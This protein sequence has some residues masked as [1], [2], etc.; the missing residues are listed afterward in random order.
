MVNDQAVLDSLQQMINWGILTTDADLRVTGLNAWFETNCGRA[1][2]EI[3]GRSLLDAFPEVTARNLDHRYRQV[4]AGSAA[5]LSQRLHGYVFAM[6]S[7]VEGSQFQLMQ[8]SV[9][10]SPLVNDGQVVGTLTLVEDVTERVAFETGLRDA[11]RRKNEF[12]AM[13]AHELRN[14]LAPIQNAIQFLRMKGPSDQDLEWARDVIERQVQQMTRLV[15]DLLDASRITTGKI[16][17]TMEPVV[18]TRIIDGALEVSRP[19]IDSHRHALS[20]SLPPK[21]V[22]LKGDS[23]RL[24][25]VLSNLLNNAAKYTPP[26]GSVALTAVH[27]GAEVVIGVRD[28]GMGIPGEMLPHIFDLFTQVNRSLDRSEGGLGI[29]LTL[30]RSLVDMHGGSVHA[31]SEGSGRGSVFL[32]RLPV[33]A[34]PEAKSA[35]AE[36]RPGS[37]ASAVSRRILVV[38]DNADSARTLALLLKKAGNTVA[39]AFTGTEAIER[40]AADRP[41]IVFLDIGLPG[42]SGL[43]VAQRVRGDEKLNSCFLVALS[44]YGQDEDREKSTAAGFDCHLVKPVNLQELTAVLCRLPVRREPTID[45]VGVGGAN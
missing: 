45:Q 41:E 6:P 30:V 32:V 20:V 42:M 11:D 15:N 18:L 13:L 36:P 39:V 27:E 16:S 23:T 40:I 9:R 19:V 35:Q 1:K 26:G 21:A 12:L 25:Q 22:W 14:P 24:V 28:S 33:L 10:I 44:G 31:S 34:P 7:S 29:G 8:Q 5:V 38:D 43:E 4:L 17:L 3:V 37:D 2:S